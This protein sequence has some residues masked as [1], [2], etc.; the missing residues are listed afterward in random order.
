[1]LHDLLRQEGITVGRKHVGT[2]MQRMGV[3]AL[4]RKPRTTRRQPGHPV[5][6]YLLRALTIT[7]ANQVWARDFTYIPLAKGFV[8][9]VAVVDW[10][11][12]RVLAWRVSITL[13]VQFCL[14]AVEE[15]LA[16]YGSPDIMNTDQGSQFTNDAFTGFIKA[17]RIRLSM[18]GRGA[19]RDNIFVERLWRSVKYEEVYLHAYESVSLARAGLTRYFQFYNSRRPHSSLGRQTPDQKYFDNPLPS[20]AA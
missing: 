15:A 19:W 11:T 4:Y 7:R 16:R 12:R 14:E 8:Y 5:Y 6:P 9:L 3:E 13:D 2:L 17:H 10:H 18:D 20:K 1:M